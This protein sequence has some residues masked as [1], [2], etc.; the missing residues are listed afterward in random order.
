MSASAA[1]SQACD[2]W[3]CVGRQS[4]WANLD[5]EIKRLAQ[6]DGLK[7]VEVLERAIALYGKKSR[8]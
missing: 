7:I 1:L 8:S 3:I 4:T 6:R 5:A 2:T